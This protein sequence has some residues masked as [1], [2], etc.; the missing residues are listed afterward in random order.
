MKAQ[1]ERRIERRMGLAGRWGE[2][3]LEQARALRDRVLE[4]GGRV[5]RVGAGA[6]AGAESRG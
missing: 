4:L 2:K 6:L 3:L 5:K 1:V